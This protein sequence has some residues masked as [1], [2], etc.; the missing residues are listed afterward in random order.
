MRPNENLD[1]TDVLQP[2]FFEETRKSTHATAKLRVQPDFFLPRPDLY[3]VGEGLMGQTLK[4]KQL[5]Y[6]LLDCGFA[7]IRVC[8][9]LAE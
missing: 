1:C 2:T 5:W 8:N 7:G 4:V 3:P 6:Y 9:I